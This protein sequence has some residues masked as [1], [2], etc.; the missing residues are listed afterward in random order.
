MPSS[1]GG[2]CGCLNQQ[3]RG[4]KRGW[5]DVGDVKGSKAAR[6]EDEEMREMCQA[7]EED[8]VDA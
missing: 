7:A 1:G 6:E 8:A 5:I 2:C 3:G 4:W